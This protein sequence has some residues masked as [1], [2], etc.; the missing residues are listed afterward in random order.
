MTTR[1]FD[2]Q[3]DRLSAATVYLK[4]YSVNRPKMDPEYARKIWDDY[5]LKV[6]PVV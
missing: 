1:Y 5:V 2:D 3:C 6:S 4:V